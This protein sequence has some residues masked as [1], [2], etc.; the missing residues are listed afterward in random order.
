MRA[1]SRTDGQFFLTRDSG[2]TVAVRPKCCHLGF[3]DLGDGRQMLTLWAKPVT[4]RV[5]YNRIP[6]ALFNDPPAPADPTLNDW[7]SFFGH[8]VMKHIFKVEQL[9]P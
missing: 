3:V 7:Q 8:Q 9:S 5:F 1:V 6:L 4:T 2:E